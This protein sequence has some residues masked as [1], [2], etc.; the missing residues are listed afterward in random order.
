MHRTKVRGIE[1]RPI[2]ASLRDVKSE[3]SPAQLRVAELAILD[4][5]AVASLTITQLATAADTSPG[6]VQRLCHALELGGYAQFRVQLAAAAVQERRDVTDNIVSARISV[7]DS[8]ASIAKKVTFANAA[9]VEDTASELDIEAL[10]AALNALGDASR[11]D[12][13]GLGSSGFVALDFQQKLH[14][15]GRVSFA[16]QDPHMTLASA[17][18]LQPGDVALGISH[19]GAT[20]E[21]IGALE[22]ARING[23]T[24]IALTNFARS[25]ITQAADHVLTTATRETTFRSDDMASRLAQLTVIDILYVGL[26]QRCATTS[27][28]SL[29]RVRSAVQRAQGSKFRHG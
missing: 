2:T 13:Y 11:I 15:I 25:R 5:R 20:A 16:W 27:R 24:T 18:L 29:E 21:T 17:A 6:T 28:D 3:L 7:D 10:E 14:Q 4:P 12:V 1:N 9:A 22:E 23:A 19:T 26:A 8:V